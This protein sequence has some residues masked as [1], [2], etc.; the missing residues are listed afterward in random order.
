MR[1]VLSLENLSTDEVRR[2]LDLSAEYKRELQGGNRPNDFSGHVMGLLFE[3][4][5]LR[6]RVSFETLFKQL[7]G[8]SLF[9]GKDVGWGEREPIRDFIP[10]LT[11]YLD[12]LVIRAKS[13]EK[14]MEACEYSRCP[15]ING[16]TD[17]SHPCQAS[18]PVR[19]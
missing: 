9:L 8:S 6:T 15:I 12:L 13:H 19:D 14:V 18:A 4:P 16:L 17:V 1:H 7:G 2:V 3:K 11:S 10:I 5:S